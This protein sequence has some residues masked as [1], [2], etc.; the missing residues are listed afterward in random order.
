MAQVGVTSRPV[1]NGPSPGSTSA[2]SADSL[3]ETEEYERI[4]QFRDAV[5]S[6]THPRIRLPAV[7]GKV[8]SNPQSA[9]GTSAAANLA[10]S[11]AGAAAAQ[12]FRLGN[13][14]PFRAN[15]QQPMAASSS[16]AGH[17]GI[18]AKPTQFDP[19][20]LTKSDVL[21]RAEFQQQRQRLEK[22]LRE[23]LDQRRA[24]N[25]AAQA[26]Q[27]VE[28]EADLD[29]PDV[30]AKALTL[31]QATAPPVDADVAANASDSSDSFDNNTFYSSQHDTPEPCVSSPAH[32][33]SDDVQMRDAP[34][35]TGPRATLHEQNQPVTSANPPGPAL[36]DQNNF[37]PPY[38]TVRGGAGIPPPF[39]PRLE[40]AYSVY[41]GGAPLS[42]QAPARDDAQ[43]MVISSNGSGTT[44]RSG[45]LV[46]T[47]R[48][49]EASR[50]QAPPPQQVDSPAQREP[51][52][53]RGHNLQPFAP[54][55]AHVSPLAMARQPPIPD[56][57]I[58]ILPGPP[59][60]VAALRQEP[61]N[62]TSPESSPQG[63]KGG[64]KK[65]KKKNKR[66][67][68]ADRPASPYI[69]PEPRSPS[70]L[71]APQYGRPA[72]RQ[73][74]LQGQQSQPGLNYDEP[75]VGPPVE[76][77]Q[78]EYV[79]RP[80]R[81]E[82]E[83]VGGY[84]RM[85]EDMYG[86]QIRQSVAPP[87]SQRLERPVH[88]DRR[89]EE[90]V[91]Y[92]RHGP[93]P[94]SYVVPHAASEVRS[95]R[96]ATYSVADAAYREAPAYYPEGRMSVRPVADRPRSRSPIML[97]PR[98]VM[99]PPRQP[100]RIMTDE[101]GREYL[102]PIP[103]PASSRLSVA[104]VGRHLEHEIVYERTPARAVSRMP[105][106]ETFERDGVLYRRASPI[107]APRRVVTQPEYGAADYRDYRDYRARE[108][109]TQPPP[110]PPPGHEYVQYF[111]TGDRQFPR[112]L[113]P[114]YG[115]RSASI[116]PPE[117]IRYDYGRVA[118]VRL[119]DVPLREHAASVH[120][121]ARREVIA[122]PYREYSVRPAEAE[123]PRHEYSVRPTERYYMEQP[124]TV[125]REVVYEDGRREVYR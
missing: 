123:L 110:P 12:D 72:K 53:I 49:A 112:E 83:P 24:A 43:P 85:V 74:P 11:Q 52:L 95:M 31:V 79:P 121:E 36:A 99:G 125:Q 2:L 80:L 47:D 69:K 46:E 16:V 8:Q 39:R 44:S 37:P 96:P 10:G 117:P 34:P 70:P 55:P 104:P 23:Q 106:P 87:V 107:S 17:G 33:A 101:F 27:P 35:P 5:L 122:P 58:S 7:A 60:Q 109:P 78:E 103:P 124:R 18:P 88:E 81:E 113:P 111:P 20:L 1:A 89:P 50:I 9:L 84:E 15:A 114:D 30:L 71:S 100:P 91:Q 86:R 42:G 98:S 54:Q 105:G 119:P 26:A 116:R 59:A 32:R 22:S 65:N 120:P 48:R 57:E 41:G 38:S 76:G 93:S 14:Q 82:R 25:K 6:G 66:K 51:R 64:K 68:A 4:V 61:A 75:R 13:L 21:I 67:A 62:G 3:H 77:V 102:E 28:H 40:G 118:S 63:E 92:A 90:A 19:L 56:Q 29:L 108:Y 97:D 45:D 94:A 115:M 73:R